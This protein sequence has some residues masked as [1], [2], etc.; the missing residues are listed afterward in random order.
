M[1]DDHFYHKE[2]LTNLLRFAAG[3]P[4]AAV[5]SHGWLAL[6]SADA[7]EA[8][9]RAGPLLA[10][11]LRNADVAGGPILC[12][13]LGLLVQR[14]MLEGLEAPAYGSPC[15]EHNDIWVSAHLAKFRIRRAMMLDPLGA[16]N[17]ATHRKRGTSLSRRRR[18]KPENLCL[19]DFWNKHGDK[20]WMPFP[21]VAV[22]TVE[23]VHLLEALSLE[24]KVIHASYSCKLAEHL[25]RHPTRP[26]PI[27][28]QHI[29]S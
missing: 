18:R 4:G 6:Q 12:H 3:T 26:G 29:V 22:C 13:F 17:L 20:L 2:L 5:G 27:W 16:K 19:K 21:R 7:S 23:S 28:V 11:N 15:S 8:I 1:D 9:S 10:R 14:S 25:P 24:G